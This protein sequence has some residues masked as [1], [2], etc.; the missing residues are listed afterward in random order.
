MPRLNWLSCFAAL[1]L[2]SGAQAHAADAVSADPAAQSDAEAPTT[3]ERVDP[4]HRD[5]ATR[6]TGYDVRVSLQVRETRRD[7]RAM[8]RDGS[9]SRGQARAF[10]KQASVVSAA[11]NRAQRRAGGMSAS[12]ARDM[13]MQ[14]AMLDSLVNAP[15]A[16]DGSGRR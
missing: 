9:M 13:G 8:R 5:P 1:A 3:A 6:G 4:N 2:V 15:M 11:S 16:Q 10:R 14:A 7:I 12:E